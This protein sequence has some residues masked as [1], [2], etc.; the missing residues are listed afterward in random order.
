MINLCNLI[1]CVDQCTDN[2]SYKAVERPECARISSKIYLILSIGSAT[3]DEVATVYE[4]LGD[5][6]STAFRTNELANRVFS[7]G[8]P[9][10]LPDGSDA[11]KAWGVSCLSAANAA[12]FVFF[13][14][15]AYLRCTLSAVE[16][17]MRV[18]R[19]FEKARS[20]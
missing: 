5:P 12:L 15:Y 10:I 16:A 2:F 8:I 7:L 6:L 13:P 1:R 11:R 17:A 18:S 20:A 4:W 14:Q 9:F 19:L 3:F